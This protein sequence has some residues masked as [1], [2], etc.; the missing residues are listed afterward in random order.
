MCYF[1][2]QTRLDL[3]SVCLCLYAVCTQV[4]HPLLC[5]EGQPLPTGLNPH[6]SMHLHQGLS[7]GLLHL[8]LHLTCLDMPLALARAM[9]LLVHLHN[10]QLLLAIEVVLNFALRAASGLLITHHCYIQLSLVISK[11][12]TSGLYTSPCLLSFGCSDAPKLAPGCYQ[13][14][15]SACNARAAGEGCLKLQIDFLFV[16]HQ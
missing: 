1:I 13:V 7:M 4:M 15:R 6:P 10:M 12:A 16:W 11:K 3:S 14:F 5:M 8:A 2:L 9:L